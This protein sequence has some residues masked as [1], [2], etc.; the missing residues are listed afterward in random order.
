MIQLHMHKISERQRVIDEYQSMV[1]RGREMIPLELDKYK[2]D[3]VIIQHIIQMIDTNILWNEE[4]FR[5]IITE[6]WKNRNGETV[7]KTS[8]ELNKKESYE[9]AMMWW[10][11]LD[12]LEPTSKKRKTHSQDEATN[13]KANEMDDKMHTKCTTNMGTH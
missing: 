13:N 5:A 9:S 1:D 6:L 3:L 12:D 8:K 10:E 4:T 11:S 7:T 2:N